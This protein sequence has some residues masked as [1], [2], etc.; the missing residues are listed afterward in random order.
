MS[1][2]NLKRNEY[3]RTLK[4]NQY[5]VLIIGGGITGAGIALDAVT[6]GLKVALVE[7][8]DFA[9]GTSSRSTK[10][11]HGGLRYLKQ[12]EV[13]M[14]AEVGKER[15]IVYEN[16]PHV[17]TPEWMVLPL[18][19]GGTFG[20]FSTSIGLRVYDYLAGV[21]KEER[22]K[23]LSSKE[24]LDYEP[25]LKRTGL[26]GGGYYVEYRTDDARLTIEVIKAAQLNGADALNYAKVVNL[27]YE[28][29]KAVG[30]VV[31]D[32]VS[33]EDFSIKANVVVNATGPWVDTIREKDHSK[34]G[35]KLRL[36]KGVHIVIDESKF[37]LQQ[38]I[39]FDTP[40]GRMIFAIPREGKTYV[41]TT[42]TFFDNDIAKPAMTNH[43]RDYLLKAINYM[44]PTVEL[45]SED[46]ESSWAGVRPLIYEEGKDPSEISRRDEIW[47][48]PS[49]L[50]TIAGGKLTGYRKMAETVVDI[51]A[52]KLHSPG[53]RSECQTQHLPISGGDVGGSEGFKQYVRKGIPAG[54]KAGLTESE[55]KRLV[56]KY[57]SNS[58][59]LFEII[60][61]SRD[62]LPSIPLSLYA[63]LAYSIAHEMVLT[64]VDFF[65]RRTG[66]LL[67]NIQ[68]VQKHKDD[69][70]GYM[71]TRFGWSD[72]ETKERVNELEAEIQKSI[73]T[74]E[75][76]DS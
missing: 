13:K 31:K 68:L 58:K 23:M 24:T 21:K 51:L 44:F 71:S 39:Y 46:I 2:S 48:S 15:E 67:F 70:I 26:K 14:V 17:T 22:R 38:A 59:V 20:K 54:V 72:S 5:D 42:D 57:G 50:I 28:E 36:S 4:E 65:Y 33:G 76:T 34:N 61:E 73:R 35:K 29:E 45:N 62:E 37:P 64:P 40:D 25:L 66:Y 10:L 27:L 55:A 69:V 56:E 52:M 63:E 19:K 7:M 43:D 49:G 1:F 8:Q 53:V 9:A 11:V 60:A 6:R 12:F 16:G 74:V 75:E 47:K 41:G 3:I 18:H 32:K 30:A